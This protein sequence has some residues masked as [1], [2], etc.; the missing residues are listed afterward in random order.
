[1]YSVKYRF[2][3]KGDVEDYFDG[4]LSSFLVAL[5]KNGQILGSWNLAEVDDHLE[6]ICITPEA[7]SL[8]RQVY[9]ECVAEEYE[10]LLKAS[11]REPDYEA[12][13]P[14]VGLGDTCD[15]ADPSSYILFTT[16]LQ[17]AP[18]V[19]CGDCGGQVPLYRL[20]FIS[21]EVEHNSILTWE[22]NFK[23]CDQLYV[24]SKGAKEDFGFKQVHNFKSE[25]SQDGIVLCRKLSDATGKP[26]YYFLVG[27]LD[28]NPK[29]CPSC[30]EN[31]CL[32][33]PIFG[34]IENKCDRCRL[35]S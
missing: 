22:G 18:P 9:S 15:C 5:K 25:L 33:E 20:P 28:K 23:A 17:V 16:F 14:A 34:W 24:C 7:E 8:D 10:K 30:G 4:P 19:L 21:D 32:D 3:P 13:G 26:F 6:L 11:E 35:V 1:M 31:W 2:Y 12:V 27:N 29:K